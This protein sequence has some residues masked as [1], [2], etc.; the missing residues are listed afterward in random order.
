V[1]TEEW[2]WAMDPEIRHE[3]AYIWAQI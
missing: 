3:E 1:Q 2:E